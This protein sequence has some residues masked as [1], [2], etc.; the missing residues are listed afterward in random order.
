[1]AGKL[2]RPSLN[3]SQQMKAF[4]CVAVMTFGKHTSTNY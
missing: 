3:I 4:E 1:M 2:V